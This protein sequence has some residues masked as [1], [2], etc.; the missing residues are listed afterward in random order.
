M[1]L[2]TLNLS[3]NNLATLPDAFGASSTGGLKNLTTLNLAGNNLTSLPETFTT[4][5]ATPIYVNNSY[6]DLYY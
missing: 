3:N 6:W 1:K 5:F 4:L 2:T